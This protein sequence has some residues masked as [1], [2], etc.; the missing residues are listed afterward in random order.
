MLP[1]P[2]WPALLVM[3]TVAPLSTKPSD[4]VVALGTTTTCGVARPLL[5]RASVPPSTVVPPVCWLLAVSV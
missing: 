2:I 4:G 5:V 3:V 1:E